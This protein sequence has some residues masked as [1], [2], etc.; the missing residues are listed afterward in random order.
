MRVR[1]RTLKTSLFPKASQWL[2][3]QDLNPRPSGY[4]PDGLVSK[5]TIKLNRHQANGPD[6]MP[7]PGRRI[8]HVNYIDCSHLQSTWLSPLTLSILLMAQSASSV[9]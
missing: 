3:G 8:A 4:E 5:R 6:L 1:K 7:A 9:R 2:R